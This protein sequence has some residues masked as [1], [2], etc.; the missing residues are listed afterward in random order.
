MAIIQGS[1][2]NIAK[3]I[4]PTDEQLKHME[5]VMAI[6]DEIRRVIANGFADYYAGDD[7]TRQ[8][9]L[10]IINE[11]LQYLENNGYKVVKDE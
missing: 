8:R 4:K 9:F 10:G 3:S 2:K 6:D 7:Y 11:V 1:L 5:Q